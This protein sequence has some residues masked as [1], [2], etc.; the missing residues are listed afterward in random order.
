M[1]FGWEV[2]AFGVDL[3]CMCE[4]C[5]SK[6]VGLPH[7]NRS[8]KATSPSSIHHLNTQQ[9]YLRAALLSVSARHPSFSEAQCWHT[10]FARYCECWQQLHA[11]LALAAAAGDGW[12]F[13]VRGGLMLTVLRPG[14]AVED[15]EAGGAAAGAARPTAAV[16]S[17]LTAVGQ[18]VGS[19]ALRL[20]MRLVTLGVDLEGV[21]LP[22]MVDLLL[23]GPQ[24]N[25]GGQQGS[26]GGGD[27]ARRRLAEWRAARQAAL[28]HVQQALEAVPDPVGAIR[29]ADFFLDGKRGERGM[30]WH[31]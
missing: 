14:T 28:L 1:G 16:R 8:S 5:I 27:A 30:W 31:L 22:G 20:M 18:A 9:V 26:A 23:Y 10:L 4:C 17:C 29:C 7:A 13:V 25:A 12:M 19:P 15:E 6:R 21:L 11:P 24:G 3:S 2:V